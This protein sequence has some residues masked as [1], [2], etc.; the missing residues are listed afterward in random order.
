MRRGWLFC[1]LLVTFA[2]G[3]DDFVVAG[4]LPGIA[5]DLG[6]GEPAAG[7]LVSVFSVIYALAARVVPTA[8][9]P[10]AIAARQQARLAAQV[11]YARIRSPFHRLYARLIAVL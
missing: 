6:V 10:A 8:A 9:A 5:R 1:L 3:T 7:Q 11:G 2:V 4:V